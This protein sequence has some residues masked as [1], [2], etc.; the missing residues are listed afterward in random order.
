MSKTQTIILS[1][2]STFI[3]LLLVESKTPWER[4]KTND[5]NANMAMP[6]TQTAQQ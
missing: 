1:L 5:N 4:G 2:I 6:T 3:C